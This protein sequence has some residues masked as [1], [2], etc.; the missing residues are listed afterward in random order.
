MSAVEGSESIVA[1]GADKGLTLPDMVRKYKEDLVGEANY[2]RFGNSFL[3]ISYDAKLDLSIQV[4]PGDELAKK[5]H[6]SFGK[7]K[8]GMLLLLTRVPS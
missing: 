6:N 8:C 4:H 5:R 3:M 2:A 1:N 7:M